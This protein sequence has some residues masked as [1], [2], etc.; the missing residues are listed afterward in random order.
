[1]QGEKLDCKFGTQSHAVVTKSEAEKLI[2][3]IEQNKNIYVVTLSDHLPPAILDKIKS[4]TK[5]RKP[6]KKKGKKKKK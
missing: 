3:C 2:S 6:K 5:K 4:L 1:M